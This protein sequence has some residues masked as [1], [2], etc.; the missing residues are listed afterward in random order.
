MKF[1]RNNFSIVRLSIV[2]S[3]IIVV[4]TGCGSRGLT[5]VTGVGSPDYGLEEHEQ[6]WD[7]ISKARDD[8]W[9]QMYNL[10]RDRPKGGILLG[11][12]L[13]LDSK[14]RSRVINHI[15]SSNVKRQSYDPQTGKAKVV[16]TCDLRKIQQLLN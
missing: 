2:A 13:A 5:T 1:L 16:I 6:K 7:A 9:M 8:A 14:L 10:V 4:L 12:Q 15:W 3:L 11:D